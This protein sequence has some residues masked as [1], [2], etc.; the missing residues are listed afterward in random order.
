[1]SAADAELEFRSIRAAF[2]TLRKLG[3]TWDGG[4]YWK[5]PAETIDADAARSKPG[6]YE[7]WQVRGG[8]KHSMDSYAYSPSESH[9]D[10]LYFH[11]DGRRG[12]K[13]A[14]FGDRLLGYVPCKPP[15]KELSS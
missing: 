6:W 8:K 4:Q 5:P 3:Y 11:L 1:M 14:P 9:F 10:F 13:P 15:F 2:A 12:P 7:V